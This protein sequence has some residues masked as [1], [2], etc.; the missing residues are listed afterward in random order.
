MRR[1]LNIVLRIE[2]PVLTRATAVARVG[3]DA[4]FLRNADGNL[5]IPGTLVKG[6]LRDA[7]RELEPCWPG[8]P[9]EADLLLGRD[10]YGDDPIAARPDRQIGRL[11]FSDWTAAPLVDDGVHHR[12]KIDTERGAASEGALQSIETVVERGDIIDFRGTIS[13]TMDEAAAADAIRQYVTVGLR[14]L[15]SIGGLTRVGYGRLADVIVEAE[16]V[17]SDSALRQLAKV[18]PRRSGDL[19]TIRLTVDRPLCI[20]RHRR[21]ANVFESEDFIPGGVLKGALAATWMEMAG[22][23][24]AETVRVGI[25]AQRP[26]LSRHFPSVRFLHAYPSTRSAGGRPI[27][28]PL[29]IVESREGYRDV[30]L[31]EKPALIA[32]SI[33]AFSMDWK[34]N[35]VALGDFKVPAT[36]RRELRVRTAVDPVTRRAAEG[37]LFAYECVLPEDLT[38]HGGV[39][40][41][42]VPED[43]REQVAAEL[44]GLLEELPAI[45]GIGKTKASARHQCHWN[46]VPISSPRNGI[47]VV[48]LRSAALLADPGQ[49][50]SGFDS[51]ALRESYARVFDELSGGALRLLGDRYFARQ[52][53]AGGSYLYHRFQKGRTP[54]RPFLLTSAGSVFVLEAQADGAAVDRVLRDWTRR[55]LDIP[56]WA[57][58]RHALGNDPG[59]R[60]RCCPYVPENGYG[61]VS[62]NEGIHWNLQPREIQYIERP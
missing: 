49:L 10:P 30:A 2:G 20:A 54:Y 7:W 28:V 41:D 60:W 23:D 14:W 27:P 11:E 48:S 62:I 39:V 47:V 5:C 38:W 18:G 59:E 34:S 32:G 46:A 61:E 4:P 43:D 8:A 45:R 12:I 58:Q 52:E 21:E 16:E 29:S 33:S 3:L 57:Q 1:N 24:R 55:G 26:A 36:P 9:P 51:D 19:L 22:L 6:R 31:L 35:P 17:R 40:F 13:F 53:L 44:A 25:D 37:Q 50:A 42:G 56:R 15:P